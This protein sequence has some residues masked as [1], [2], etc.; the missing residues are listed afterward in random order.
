MP[1]ALRLNALS[2]VSYALTQVQDSLHMPTPELH[3]LASAVEKRSCLVL[4]NRAPAKRC[5]FF[6]RTFQLWTCPHLISLD[7][8]AHPLPTQAVQ[9][10]DHPAQRDAAAEAKCLAALLAGQA[11]LLAIAAVRELRCRMQ[12]LQLHPTERRQPLPRLWRALAAWVPA[13]PPP[14]QAPSWR[15]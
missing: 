9:W 13:P 11:L 7:G 5:L 15:R 4:S 14:K 10:A 12:F 3:D 6:T 8:N 2:L 1:V